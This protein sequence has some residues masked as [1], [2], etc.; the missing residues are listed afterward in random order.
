MLKLIGDKA[1]LVDAQRLRDPATQPNYKRSRWDYITRTP[2][3]PA[4]TVASTAPR[5][6]PPV[7]EPSIEP[8]RK[9]CKKDT[10][11]PT[12]T[13]KEEAP[14]DTTVTPSTP[15]GNQSA[16]VL[17]KPV[18]SQPM[19]TVNP[20]K[21]AKAASDQS[22]TDTKSAKEVKKEI[23]QTD[24]N[25]PSSQPAP[26]KAPPPKPSGS[27]SSSGSWDNPALNQSVK[28]EESIKSAVESNSRGWDLNSPH[29]TDEFCATDP[30]INAHKHIEMMTSAETMPI[31]SGMPKAS[32]EADTL[33][34]AQQRLTRD[35]A[36]E[37]FKDRIPHAG[38]G[39]T[40]FWNRMNAKQVGF[41]SLLA[42]TILRALRNDLMHTKTR[43][44]WLTGVQGTVVDTLSLLAYLRHN[45]FEL[46][47]VTIDDLR[48]L[49]TDWRDIT[50][51]RSMMQR[52]SVPASRRMY[53]MSFGMCCRTN[54][55]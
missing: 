29:P 3:S 14:P 12:T 22:S 27:L 40:K 33:K 28:S 45:C 20:D 47:M 10:P 46:Q 32:R 43:P 30:V 50:S 8:L 18:S 6:P 42:K 2:T 37:V 53:Q 52:N 34:A 39:K 36:E 25:K 26:R 51:E 49:V 17:P 23:T 54:T 31:P 9:T 11:T 4:D 35:D 48:I 13:P 19:S 44:T 5:R 21:N 15:A 55:E 38:Q 1:H 16:E 24:S 41:Y 7:Q